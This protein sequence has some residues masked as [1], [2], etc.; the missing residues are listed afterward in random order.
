MCRESGDYVWP[1]YAACPD[2]RATS[3]DNDPLGSPPKFQATPNEVRAVIEG[4][5]AMIGSTL[6]STKTFNPP[7]VISMKVSVKRYNPRFPRDDI[8]L[9][10]TSTLSKGTWHAEYRVAANGQRFDVYV[11][12][13]DSLKSIESSVVF[14]RPL[15]VVALDR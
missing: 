5:G 7:T 10:P 3:S 13:S 8:P 9:L 12:E 15:N 6:I 1:I 4:V 11:S 2:F 14:A